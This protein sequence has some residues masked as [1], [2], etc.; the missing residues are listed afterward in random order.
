MA[1]PVNSGRDYAQYITAPFS[2]KGH[3]FKGTRKDPAGHTVSGLYASIVFP[4]GLA[5]WEAMESV[6]HLY[7][8]KT[9]Y[10]GLVGGDHGGAG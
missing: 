1:T 6:F 2:Y 7:D 10:V 5:H 8:L 3:D 4:D 9:S